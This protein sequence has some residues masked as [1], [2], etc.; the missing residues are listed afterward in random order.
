MLASF[1]D[2]HERHLQPFGKNIPCD[3]AEHAAD[4]LPMAHRRR[5]GDQLAVVEDRQGEDHV[6]QVAAHHLWIIGEQDVARL[7]I[8]FAPVAKLRLDRIREA[9]D[10]HR[11]AKSDGNRVAVGVEKPDGK[12]LGLIDDHVVGGAHEIGLHL[13]RDRHHRAA[14]HLRRESVDARLVILSLFRSFHE[15]FQIR[16]NRS[17]A[18]ALSS[19]TLFLSQVF[20]SYLVPALC[21]LLSYL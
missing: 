4:V 1:E 7:D 13:I 2:L 18:R 15:R 11:Q 21:V 8:F 19:R 12:I 5:E 20:L 17:I 3:G 14:D 10:E 6:I 16:S 9:A